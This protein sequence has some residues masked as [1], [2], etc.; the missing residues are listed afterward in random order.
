MQQLAI[1]SIET[2]NIEDAHGIPWQIFY[3]IS[4][5]TRAFWSIVNARTVIGYAPDDDSEVQFAA[6]IQRLL[7]DKP[8]RT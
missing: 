4:G 6:D 7:A 2:E 5:N 1:K 8:G 3:G